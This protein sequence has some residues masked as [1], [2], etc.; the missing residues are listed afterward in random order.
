VRLRIHLWAFCLLLVAEAALVPTVPAQPSPSKRWAVDLESL[1]GQGATI[2]GCKWSQPIASLASSAAV[3]AVGI[4]KVCTPLSPDRTRPRAE[5]LRRSIIFFLDPATGRVLAKFEPPPNFANF[6]LFPTSGRNFILSLER[7]DD[8]ARLYSNFLLLISSAGQ[9]IAETNL[10]ESGVGSGKT[11]LRIL[12]SPTRKTMVVHE[13]GSSPTAFAVLDTD[14]L[15]VQ[16]MRKTQDAAEP[17]AICSSDRQL[18]GLAGNT[19][20]SQP[21]LQHVELDIRTF[22]G[23]WRS[24]VDTVSSPRGRPGCAFLNEEVIAKSEV[25]APGEGSISK[26]TLELLRPNGEVIATKLLKKSSWNDL[27]ANIVT[28]ASGTS[29]YLAVR[30]DSDSHFWQALDAARIR[31][32]IYVLRVRDLEPVWK[33]NAGEAVSYFCFSPEG[34]E[35]YFVDRKRLVAYG[36]TPVI[37]SVP[38]N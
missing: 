23:R 15:S 1:W 32:E 12:L 20:T 31:A 22:E 2:V 8:S 4:K 27:S 5:Q 25:A 6:R 33:L 18:V 11:P 16:E 17:N 26:I 38:S 13:S 29:P 34:S 3:V 19:P 9:K 21:W 10:M 28:S 14:S 37:S 35:L 30:V 36:L 7:F 24:L